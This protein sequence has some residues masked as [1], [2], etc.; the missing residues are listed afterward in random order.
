MSRSRTCS[1]PRASTASAF[2][3]TAACGCGPRTI[4]SDP[5]WKYVKVRRYFAY[6][7]HSIGKGTQ[8]A[9]FE[10]NGEQLWAN[11]RRTIEDFLMNE[12]RSGGLLGDKPE[13]TYFVKCD[14]S[15]SQNDLDNRR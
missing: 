8:W 7:E 2:S 9:V 6:L 15:T 12:W 1:L 5:E 10:P 14:C 3:K 13:K 4:S 11:V